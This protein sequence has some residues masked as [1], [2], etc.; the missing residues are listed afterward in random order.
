MLSVTS[1][2]DKYAS[3]TPTNSLN[4]LE[5]TNETPKKKMRLAVLPDTKED[6]HASGPTFMCGAMMN[7]LYCKLHLDIENRVKLTQGST[8]FNE[9]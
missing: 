1:F 8:M 9:E 3:P 4:E 6:Q 5:S 7:Q 2:N